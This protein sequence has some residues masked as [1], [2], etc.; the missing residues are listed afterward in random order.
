MSSTPSQAAVLGAI[1]RHGAPGTPVTVSEVADALG[2]DPEQ[3]R[4]RLSALAE[5][6]ALSRKRVGSDTVVWW[7]PHEKVVDGGPFSGERGRLDLAIQHSPLV[8]FGLDTDL[9]YCW[10]E[11]AHPDFDEQAVLGKRDDDLL[12][13]DAAEAV[14]APKR[15]ALET[16]SRVREEVSYELPSG[17]VTYDLAVHPVHDEDDEVVGLACVSFDVTDRKRYERALERRTAELEALN[18]LV[19]H[20]IRND[21]AVILGWA[22]LLA[23]HVDEAGE[24]S[25]ERILRSGQRVVDLTEAARET[26]EALVG[27]GDE[28]VEPTPLRPALLTEVDLAREAFPA[29]TIEIA[30]PVPDVDVRANEMLGSV[31]KNV[32]RNAVSHSD[33]DQPTVR[34]SATVDGGALELRVADDGPGVPDDRKAVIFQRGEKGEESTGTGIGL[35]LV[36][37]L[38]DQYGGD[39]WVEDNE[40]RGAVFVVRLETPVSADASS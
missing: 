37:I 38:L 15:R 5:T 10:V 12:P 29:A 14:L 40:P 35:Y 27:E 9:R 25:L 8:L 18:R 26:I 32:I 11:N 6:G 20:D 23:D 39:V 1:E 34:V 2:C 19:R 33:R 28:T 3:A 7:L 22:E 36:Q 31:F 4:E 21:M 24:P 17:S 13:P 30:E 16:G